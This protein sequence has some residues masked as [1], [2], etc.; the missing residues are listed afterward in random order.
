MHNLH[1]ANAT[2][3]AS[4]VA[5]DGAPTPLDVTTYY[6]EM[7]APTDLRPRP[8]PDAN[9]TVQE[10]QVKQFAV[11]RFLYQ[12]V[13]DRWQWWDML[14]WSDAQWQSYAESAQLRTW[15]G[16]VQGSPAGYYELQ[17]QADQSV[18]IA[19]FGLAPQFIGQGYGGY[20]LSHAIQSA[21]DWGTER[22]WVH[23]C[24]LDHPH[25]LA[26]YQARGF[27]LYRQETRR[28]TPRD[29]PA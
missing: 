3:T 19:Y 18:K 28:T 6:L 24:T 25:A 1:S 10:C 2:P 21:W 26:N 12:F 27:R 23:T 9:F 7:T 22:V 15:I 14:T 20:F 29:R 13:G 16:Y 4:T 8:R 17:R 11:N 5:A